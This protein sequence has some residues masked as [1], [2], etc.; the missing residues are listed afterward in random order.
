MSN[1]ASED[2]QRIKQLLTI[3]AT[4]HTNLTSAEIAM[5]YGTSHGDISVDEVERLM[6]LAQ[7][8]GFVERRIYRTS[9]RQ[10]PDELMCDTCRAATDPKEVWCA[11]CGEPH[12]EEEFLLA[13]IE[14]RRFTCLRCGSKRFTIAAVAREGES[15]H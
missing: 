11:M 7:R 15:A 4:S 12:D 10:E 13:A 8:F 3:L 1:P 5:L 2:E 9:P 6:T 14:G